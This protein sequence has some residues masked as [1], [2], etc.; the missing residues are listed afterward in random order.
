MSVE[1]ALDRLL[2]QGEFRSH[3]TLDHTVP[4]KQARF[5][6]FPDGLDMRLGQALA[7]RGI[8]RL[9][10]HQ[11]EAANLALAG[12]DLVVVT[13]TASGKTACYNLPVLQAMLKD[14]EARALY[15]FPTKALAQDQLAELHGMVGELK[16]DLKTYTY[17]GDTPVSARQAIRQA[18]HI[19]VTNPDMLHTAVL[20]HHTRWVKL[21][22][23]LR[24]VVIDELHAYRGVFGSHLAN[25]LRRLWRVCDFYN[26]HPVVI[27]CSATIANPKELAE[28]LT[29]RS[30]TL[31]DDNGA[32]RG[33]KRLLFYN[34]PVVNKQLGIRRSSTLESHRIAETFLRAGVQT[35]VFGRTRLQVE[36]LL[37]YLQQSLANRLGDHSA[38]RGYRGGYLPLQRR[39]IEHGLRDGSVRGVVS[40]NALELGIDIGHLDAA[41]LCGYPG[42]IASTWQQIGRAG[43]RRSAAAAVYV[44]SSSPLDQ[45]LVNHP[46]YFLGRDPEHGLIDPDN[47]LILSAHLQAA[48]FELPLPSGER[49]GGA[50]VAE[51]LRILEEDGA[52][53][54]AGDTWHWSS[55]AFPAEGVSLRSANADNVVIVDV[56]R[57]ASIIGEMDQFSAQIFLH[58]E[59]IYLHEG[60]QYHVDRLDW[61]EKKAYVRP[62]KVD[63]YT[64]ANLA[65]SIKVL[66]TMNSAPA[67]ELAVHHGEVQIRAL[68]TIFKKIRFHSHENIGSGP[69][70][71]PEQQ[72]HTTAFW[73]EV[74]EPVARQFPR[75]AMQ[76]GL[77]GVANV[78]SQVAC[79]FLMCD[80]RDLGAHPE[81]RAPHTGAPTVYVYERYPGGVGMSARLFESAGAVLK[82]ALDL[83]A[84]CECESGCPSCVGPA[85]EVGEGGKAVAMRLL[86]AGALVPAR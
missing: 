14:K 31:V 58:E 35:I 2:V 34:P 71:L 67:S 63:Y 49:F 79:L 82:A 81:I 39:E 40:T 50:P 83:V 4:A 22:A 15:L 42:T 18:G 80:A 53:H 27:C 41:V 8:T 72:L 52:V 45:Y 38:I 66:E 84:Q 13:P 36:I 75:P 77:Q 55:D 24:Y 59:A 30:M 70:S 46:E 74:P 29:G 43:R 73:V 65:V 62:V 20:P 1:M 78:V 33:P 68:A 86:E 54:Q 3:L 21:F 7:A 10:T 32:P 11:A 17:D 6:N 47:L 12:K 64:D 61:D 26:S 51:L 37:S 56:T 44:A 76:G 28:R 85:L 9:Y 5:A 23:N 57:G 25:V 19:V 69:I 16:V 60:A 48:T